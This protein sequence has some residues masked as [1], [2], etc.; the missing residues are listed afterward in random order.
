MCKCKMQK[1]VSGMLQ[2]RSRISDVSKLCE[3]VCLTNTSLVMYMNDYI[4]KFYF[5]Q[6]SAW[7]C[8]TRIAQFFMVTEGLPVFAPKI[9]YM[10]A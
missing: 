4:Y 6:T 7:H 3:S 1:S 5:Y 8:I 9:F 10:C 2:Y